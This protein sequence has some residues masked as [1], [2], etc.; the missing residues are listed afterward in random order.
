VPRRVL[1]TAREKVGDVLD[2][3]PT[4]SDDLRHGD[5]REIRERGTRYLSAAFAT[6][7]RSTEVACRVFPRVWSATN[8][9]LSFNHE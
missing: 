6:R 4:R 1:I 5:K 9:K 3:D 7:R 8:E 2:G